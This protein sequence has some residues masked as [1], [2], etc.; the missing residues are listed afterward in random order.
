MKKRKI[1]WR[2]FYNKQKE[3]EEDISKRIC[4]ITHKIVHDDSGSDSTLGTFHLFLNKEMNN[5]NC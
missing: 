3:K 5:I 4:S 1:E 2:S